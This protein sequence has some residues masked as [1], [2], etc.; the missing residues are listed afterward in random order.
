M[1][2]YQFLKHF[3]KHKDKHSHELY[4]YRSACYVDVIILLDWNTTQ[5]SL[6][7]T[8]H[9]QI[10]KDILEKWDPGTKYNKIKILNGG[11]QEWLQRYP[12]FATN[13][14]VDNQATESKDIENEI[15]ETIEYPEWVNEN[16]VE[17]MKSKL[18]N[19]KSSINIDEEM[20]DKGD[21][22]SVVPKHARSSNND[23][24]SSVKPKS[25]TS[26]VT[27]SIDSKRPSSRI[28]NVNAQLES[29]DALVPQQKIS[30][31]KIV[32]QN[33]INAKPIIDR[34]SKPTALTNDS[35][36]KEILK[37]KKE[38]TELARSKL[39]LT[40]EL[41][42]HECALYSQHDKYS[43]NDEKYLRNEIKS[44]ND[45]VEAMVLIY[46]TIY[47]NKFK[48]FTIYEP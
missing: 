27:I 47:L 7:T 14:N 9:L 10:L 40:E 20:D 43:A 42:N 36:C 48:F 35:R 22:K 13:P 23:V 25:F 2:G 4:S 28:G 12:A 32:P 8:T 19:T 34:S 24:I 37:L 33:E 41:L 11:Y 17:I 18:N 16:E 30:P 1:L 3:D 6:T 21:N 46:L 31:T 38:L 44:L 15:L 5:E 39:K 26:Q 45:K 29:P